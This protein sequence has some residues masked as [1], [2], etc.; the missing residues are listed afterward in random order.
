MDRRII[1]IGGADR[2]SFLQNLVTNDVSAEDDGLV[3]AA[4]L[5]PQGKYLVDFFLVNRGDGILLDVAEPLA[6]D[7]LRRLTMYKLRADVT[8]GA[9]DGQV[10]LGIG[11]VPD[12]ALDD[13][14]HSTLGWRLYGAGETL[15]DPSVDW[16]AT[17]VAACIPESGIEL[18]PNETYLL[19]AGFERLNGINFRKGCYVGQ[20]VVARMKHKTELRK[21]YVTVEIDGT[22]PIGT[23]ITA[24]GKTVGQVYT[25]SG[26]RAIAYIRYDRAMGEMVA[27][28][29]A[30]RWDGTKP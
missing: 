21:G 9:F 2:H 18:I 27:D 25:Q 8:L 23:D 5:T 30:V 20:E 19:E 6:D 7:L 28:D 16:D 11:D 13:P 10:R 17:R 15:A 12:G 1:E 26:G 4:L 3:Y 29:V 22:V 24:E 14:R